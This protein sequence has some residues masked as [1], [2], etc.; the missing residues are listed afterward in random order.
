MEAQTGQ[1]EAQTVQLEDKTV[2]SPE[3]KKWWLD[4][5]MS[6]DDAKK[7]LSADDLQW[8]TNWIKR[9]PL[10]ELSEPGPAEED[11]I[12]TI[13]PLV[14]QLMSPEQL[15]VIPYSTVAR[16]TPLQRASLS[17][18]QLVSLQKAPAPAPA[19]K[20]N[21][22]ITKI[23]NWFK[24]LFGISSFT[25]MSSIYLIMVMVMVVMIINRKKITSFINRKKLSSFGKRRRR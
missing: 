18:T 21:D 3:I 14:I 20:E 17:P 6:A 10:S 9:I 13:P 11:A 24:K 2:P 23:I 1:L 5:P 4:P 19:P 8:L 12:K 15:S 16:M 7:I 25:G 22:I